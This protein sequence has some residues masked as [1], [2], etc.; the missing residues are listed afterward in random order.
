MRSAGIRYRV[1]DFL[2][3]HPPFDVMSEQD[4]LTLASTG[5][6]RFYESDETV[7]RS[8]AGRTPY[9]YVVQQG[10][11]RQFTETDGTR[12][13]QD[14][15][16]EGDLIGLGVLLEAS[17][18]LHTVVTDSDVVLYTI[19]ADEF[20]RTVRR[21]PAAVGYLSSWFTMKRNFPAT[22]IENSPF[23]GT[24]T[25]S[26]PPEDCL[27]S[28]KLDPLAALPPAPG[29]SP[30]RTIREAVETMQSRDTHHVC[31]IDEGA[32]RGVLSMNDLRD[33]VTRGDGALDVRIESIAVAELPSMPHGLPPSEYLL[34]MLERGAPMVAIGE[35]R[36]TA[37]PE[38]VLLTER[39]LT[40]QCNHSPVT[41]QQLMQ[42]ANSTELLRGTRARI[43]SQ[44]V[45]G[46]R[47][48][49][50]TGW[51]A[52]VADTLYRSLFR[53]IVE[54]CES[55]SPQRSGEHAW[56]LTGAAGRGETVIDEFPRIALLHDDSIGRSGIESLRDLA[57]AVGAALE[58]AGFRTRAGVPV[59]VDSLAGWTR[60]YSELI[61][62][63]IVQRADQS[64]DLFDIAPLDEDAELPRWLL[65]NIRK[66]LRGDGG[67]FVTLMANDAMARLPP[68]TFFEGAVID[69]LGERHERF[70]LRE[71]TLRPLVD[72]ARVLALHDGLAGGLST[73]R[74]LRRSAAIHGDPDRVLE[75]SGDA[76]TAAFRLYVT[77]LEQGQSPDGRVDPSEFDRYDQRLLKSVFHA[78]LTLL[79]KVA[80]DFALVARR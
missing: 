11:L 6:V 26:K 20:L 66:E 4:L 29:I 8:G 77:T 1:A 52:K 18:Y 32:L 40:L 37:A 63:P 70:D 3:R 57:G 23:S 60:R 13:L 71:A 31:I 68:L 24:L 76:F 19:R 9:I 25:G 51:H 38:F 10:A 15:L 30:D 45:S 56:L 79:R 75:E 55:G 35:T 47:H 80:N 48:T 64:L 44:L 67:R 61:R 17:H 12:I 54:L 27:E 7:C 42:G 16:G 14:I 5:R 69:D 73:R 21:Y 49:S 74:R 2:H 39:E 43:D 36:G 58:A 59:P 28:G 78:I 46:L 53:R 22:L 34:R 62:D 33:L 72:I 41:L 65:E 50:M